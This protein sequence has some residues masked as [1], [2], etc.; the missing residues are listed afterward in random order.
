MN[1]QLEF[2]DEIYKQKC[3]DLQEFT[4]DAFGRIMTEIEFKR[5]IRIY[6]KSRL[7]SSPSAEEMFKL[8]AKAMKIKTLYRK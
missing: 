3:K 8:V 1:I 2:E 4:F 6:D 5:F 7:T